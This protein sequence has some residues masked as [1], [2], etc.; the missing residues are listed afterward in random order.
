MATRRIKPQ[1]DYGV[2]RIDDDTNCAHAWR[3]SLRRNGRRFV[4]NF[5]DRKY[6]GGER[7]L[8]AARTYRDQLLSENPPISRKDFCSI[9]RSNNKSGTTGVC[10][11]SKRYERR[12]GSIK[13][14]WYWEASWPNEIGES[15]RKLFSVEKYGEEVARQMAV[16][17]RQ[18]AIA[19]LSGV[20]WVSERGVVD[21]SR[22]LAG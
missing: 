9:R 11:Y 2:S 13:E 1:E 5:P 16:R 19:R 14:N 15:T 10:S 22:K 18:E 21:G 3:V 20:F 12:D 17:A 4:R 7:A 8:H 6:G